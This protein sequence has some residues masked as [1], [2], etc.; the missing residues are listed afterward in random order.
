MKNN[1]K[2]QATLVAFYSIDSK[3]TIL[4]NLILECQ[5][6]IESSNNDIYKNKYSLDQIHATII[7]LEEI[8]YDLN[9]RINKNF[10]KIRNEKKQMDVD[11]FIGYLLQSNI[12]PFKI[13]IG[14]FENRDYSF[15]CQGSRPYIQSFSI[16]NEI[17]VLKGWP[18]LLRKNGKK[19]YPN[20]L[21]K[22]RT[23]AQK[24]GILHAYHSTPIAIDNDFYFRIG[25]IN[26]DKMKNIAKIENEIRLLL[27]QKDPIIIDV[28]IENLFIVK[29]FEGNVSLNS[30]SII[31]V[32]HLQR[33]NS[34]S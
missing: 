20:I 16:K 9:K 28:N 34:N 30:Q 21:N 4:R 29:Y 18:V 6:I 3:P 5:K 25:I 27:S 26:I 10:L 22:L 19:E 2:E 31:D 14:G 13:Q 17:A 15:Q 32:Q 1:K 24:F 23:K 8:T 33:I 7:G 11:N 12:F